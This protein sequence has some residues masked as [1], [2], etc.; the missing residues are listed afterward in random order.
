MAGLNA[1]MPDAAAA[2]DGTLGAAASGA[3]VAAGACGCL[4]SGVSSRRSSSARIRASYVLFQLP[5]LGADLR[6]VL[7]AAAAAA[8]SGTNDRTSATA[9]GATKDRT[10]GALLESSDINAGTQPAAY[11][12]NVVGERGGARLW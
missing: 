3:G 9:P 7:V 2:A 11:Q 5:D 12:T 4:A 10:T 8:A 1:A 6:E